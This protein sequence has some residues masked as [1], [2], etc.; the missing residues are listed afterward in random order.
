MMGGRIW[1]ESEPG[2]G[3]KFY[4]TVPTKVVEAQKPKELVSRDF[5]RSIRVLVVDD[6]QANRRILKQ[7]LESWEVASTAIA[8][9]STALKELAEAQQAGQPYGLILTDM[10]MPEMDG[11]M[12]V[13]EVRRRKE[14]GTMVIMM[15]TS[16]GHR[17]D[18]E[19]CRRSGVSAYLY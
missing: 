8:D 10:H 16:A 12:L 4:F 17:E 6:N 7:M 11:F 9:G 15:L 1:L 2:Q 18:T 13:E 14:L 19:R 5:L 3:S